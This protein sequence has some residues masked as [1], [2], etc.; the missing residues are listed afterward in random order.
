M[1]VAM[2]KHKLLNLNLL[3]EQLTQ[4]RGRI[5]EGFRFNQVSARRKGTLQKKA[6]SNDHVGSLHLLFTYKKHT[7][8]S[9]LIFKNTLKVSGGVP[10][11]VQ[12]ELHRDITCITNDKVLSFVQ[13]VVNLLVVLS[14]G[15]IDVEES[16]RLV[17]INA[18]HKGEPIPRFLEFCQTQVQHNKDICNNCFLPLTFEKGAIATCHVYPFSGSNMSAKIQPS[19]SIQYMGFKD[20]A[21]I[22]V[23]SQMLNKVIKT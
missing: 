7:K 10:E 1:F 22:H 4:F 8:C 18:T 20:I 5:I 6:T 15:L 16:V 12:E 2:S 13:M 17:N 9:V 23:Y 3:S 19:G 11:Y 14:A 21:M